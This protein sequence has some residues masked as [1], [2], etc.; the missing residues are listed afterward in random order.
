M[1]W[2]I[3]KHE[4]EEEEADTEFVVRKCKH[5]HVKGMK[6]KCIRSWAY[7]LNMKPLLSLPK[8]ITRKTTDNGKNIV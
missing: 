4:W 2:Q 1:K 8:C 5:C 6:I 7:F 3:T